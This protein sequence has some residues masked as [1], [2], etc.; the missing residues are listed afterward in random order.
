M[1]SLIAGF[2]NDERTIISAFLFTLYHFRFN[3][4]LKTKNDNKYPFLAFLSL[5]FL[6]VVE[7]ICN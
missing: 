1:I 3:K 4:N 6:F 5:I 2:F 7:H